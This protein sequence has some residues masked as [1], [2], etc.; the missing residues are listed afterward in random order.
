MVFMQIL[1]G[2]SCSLKPFIIT[3]GKYS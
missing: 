3:H 1:K 2:L